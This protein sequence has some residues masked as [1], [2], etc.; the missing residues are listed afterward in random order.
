MIS[1]MKRY[2]SAVV[3]L[4]KRYPRAFSE[5]I[6]VAVS[7]VVSAAAI[8][9]GTR[10]LTQFVLPPEYGTF[11]LL[12]GL[13]LLGKT[14]LINPIYQAQMRLFAPA[15]SQD[16]LPVFRRTLRPLAIAAVVIVV[17][18]LVLGGLGY[19]LATKDIGFLSFVLL[20]AAVPFDAQ[21]VYECNL[22]NV[23]RRQFA[24]G[25][26]ITLESIVRPATL[27]LFAVLVAPTVNSLLV[28]TIV[29][30]VLLLA[31]TLAVPRRAGLPIPAGT[32]PDALLRQQLLKYALPLLPLAVVN[33]IIQQ[34][35]RYLVGA[36]LTEHDVGV[37]SAIYGLASQPFFLVQMAFLRLLVPIYFDAV[38]AGDVAKQRKTE[39]MWLLSVAAICGTGLI[40]IVLLQHWLAR[41]FVGPEYRSGANLMGWIALGYLFFSFGSVFETRLQGQHRTGRIFAANAIGSVVALIAPVVL[42]RQYGLTGCAMACPVY[43]F[44]ASL[45]MWALSLK[46]RPGD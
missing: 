35:S 3:Q 8:L 32:E 19:S 36:M 16:R 34:S 40:L 18:L 21:R 5:G 31:P 28:A 2:L 17:L 37:Y 25:A 23:G 11:S 24:L 41:L 13:V 45:A 1:L 46:H 42:I 33:W 15:A 26:M 12:M 39:R 43:F 22:M 6:W 38:N 9:I 20:A 14:A 30:T 29:Q 44:V 10:L 4:P 27:V 7:H